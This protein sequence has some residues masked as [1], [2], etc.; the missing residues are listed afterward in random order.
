MAWTRADEYCTI[1]ENSNDI[2]DSDTAG[3]VDNDMSIG[4]P[5]AQSD[6][7]CGDVHLF[8]RTFA[9]PLFFN[10]YAPWTIVYISSTIVRHF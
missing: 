6:P 5:R 1:S 10:K 8:R 9:S 7:L 3:V 4:G 2:A